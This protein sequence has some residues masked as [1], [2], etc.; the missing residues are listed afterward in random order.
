[1]STYKLTIEYDGTA[2]AGWQYQP[3]QPTVQ[4]RLESVLHRI[5]QTSIS[6]IAAGRTDAGVHALGQVISFRSNKHLTEPEW[7]RAL[8]GLL[9]QD[10]GIT[11]IETVSD[12][13]HA[14]YSALAKIYEYR[15]LNA[16]ARSPLNRHRVWHIPQSLNISAMQ[17]ASTLFLGTHDCSALQGSRTDT[18]NPICTIQQLT[19]TYED[20]ILRIHIQADRFLKQMVRTL[21]GT[22]VEIGHGKRNPAD[23]T[24]ILKSSDRRCAGKTAPPQ[25]LYLIRVLY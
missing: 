14:R 11:S 3:D 23:I 4:E 17:E 13:F 21:V 10:I 9:P 2:Y 5:T 7:M 24:N 20:S 12:T 16:R 19:L 25:G 18:E 15:I 22:L 8:N 1:M 6:V